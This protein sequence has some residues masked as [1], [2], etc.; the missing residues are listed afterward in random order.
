MSLRLIMLSFLIPGAA[1]AADLNELKA[2]VTIKF[3][4]D[5]YV[6]DLDTAHHPLRDKRAQK[7]TEVDETAPIAIFGWGLKRRH[8]PAGTEG[9]LLKD[10]YVRVISRGRSS[11]DCAMVFQVNGR[12]FVLVNSDS[13]V[14]DDLNLLTRLVRTFPSVAVLSTPGQVA[15]LEEKR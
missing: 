13:I 11:A 1:F 3:T 2:G 15:A 8:L 6:Y 7:W 4:K 12:N 14:G 9:V 10:S 5:T